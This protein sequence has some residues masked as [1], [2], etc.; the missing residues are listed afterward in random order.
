M[1]RSYGPGLLLLAALVFMALPAF[2]AFAQG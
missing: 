2:V 1:I